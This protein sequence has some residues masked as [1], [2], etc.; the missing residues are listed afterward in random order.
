MSS[1]RRILKKSAA[2]TGLVR[3]ARSLLSLPRRLGHRA[4]QQRLIQTYL[5][6]HSVRKL[7]IGAGANAL[8]GWLSTDKNLYAEGI[9]YLDAT[10][11]FP[12]ADG[13]FD[14]IYSEHMIEHIPWTAGLAMLR[15]CRRVLKPGGRIRVATPD[16]RVLAG[17]YFGQ[18][19]AT[20]E[21]YVRWITELALK[22]V[23][24]RPAFVLNSA[25]HSWGHKFLY[26]E[27]LLTLAL[28][29]AG[30]GGIRRF[31]V[32]QSDEAQLRGIESHGAHAANAEMVAFETMVLE[33][34]CP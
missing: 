19:G 31:S 8:P 13:S 29:R 4:E 18:G 28:Q 21:Q 3:D 14:C 25:F 10:E 32:G 11:R 9:V 5:D 6:G 17:L 12:F 26:D 16:L 2:L 20:G 1:I 27:E 30:F 34:A 23:P 15:E 33:A 24:P 7:Q 22:D